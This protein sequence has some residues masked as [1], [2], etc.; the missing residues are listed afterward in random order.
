[1]RLRKQDANDDYQFGHNAADFWHNEVDGVAQSVKTRLLLYRGEWFLDQ[2]EG[3][4]WGGFPLNSAVVRQG[5]VLGAHTALSRDVAVRQ[6][7]LQTFGVRSILSYTSSGDVNQRTFSV[8][9]TIDTIYGRIQLGIEPDYQEP[10][11]I[12]NWSY[13]TGSDPL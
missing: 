10:W 5:Q 12:V 11:F 6:R 7:V 8:R 3:M 13:V 9:M 1:M 2:Q 4:P